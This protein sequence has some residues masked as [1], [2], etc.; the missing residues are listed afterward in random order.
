MLKQQAEVRELQDK[1]GVNLTGGCLS[2]ILQMPIF[3]GLYNVIQNIPAYVN[4]VKDLYIPIA[5]AIQKD[6]NAFDK[7]SQYKD[8]VGT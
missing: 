5:D 2:A 3:F 6:S 7:L 4:K 8:G 1:Y